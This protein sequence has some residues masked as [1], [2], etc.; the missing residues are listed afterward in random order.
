MRHIIARRI[1]GARGILC[2]NAELQRV[3]V[4]QIGVDM[5]WRIL[6]ALD[7]AFS[8]SAVLAALA[9]GNGVIAGRVPVLQ[10]NAAW[11]SKLLVGGLTAPDTLADAALGAL[12]LPGA[13]LLFALCV[14]SEAVLITFSP[15]VVRIAAVVAAQKF[16][17]SVESAYA[18]VVRSGATITALRRLMLRRVSVSLFVKAAVAF[19]FGVCAG[20]SAWGAA[21]LIN[22][23]TGG[24]LQTV[25]VIAVIVVLVLVKDVMSEFLKELVADDESVEVLR[26][27]FTQA[28][29]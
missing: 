16:E 21:A 28:Q 25:I 12:P 13:L 3:S 8:T 24:V 22:R 29:T 15:L 18:H 7:V 11:F 1:I 23:N 20:L 27:K 9:L 17:L 26:A 5:K 2:S 10:A 4:R 19:V 6:A 14:T